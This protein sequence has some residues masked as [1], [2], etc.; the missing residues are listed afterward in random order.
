MT[1]I[2]DKY[3]MTIAPGD[4]ETS[5]CDDCGGVIR[6][7]EYDLE[8]EGDDVTVC[9]GCYEEY[10]ECPRCGVYVHNAV[11]MGMCDCCEND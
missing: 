2:P 8:T 11:S 1:T 4:L 5:V 7:K 6:G 9:E 10:H 3:D